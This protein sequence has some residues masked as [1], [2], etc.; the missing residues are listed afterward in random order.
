M[1][2]NHYKIQWNIKSTLG[3][4]DILENFVEWWDRDVAPT[5]EMDVAGQFVRFSANDLSKEECELSL[6]WASS[7]ENVDQAKEFWENWLKTSSVKDSLEF[8]GKIGEFDRNQ[9]VVTGVTSQEVYD[10]I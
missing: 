7:Y 3:E 6:C 2:E 8:F 4:E 10:S 1:S 9:F 5:K